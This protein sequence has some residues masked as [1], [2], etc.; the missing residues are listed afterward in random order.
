MVSSVQ[1]KVSYLLLPEFVEMGTK[2]YST[3]SAPCHSYPTT[4]TMPGSSILRGPPFWK[5]FQDGKHPSGSVSVSNLVSHY[6]IKILL[7]SFPIPIF[8]VLKYV[9]CQRDCN[10]Y[11]IINSSPHDLLIKSIHNRVCKKQKNRCIRISISVF[12]A[13]K[14]MHYN[15]INPLGW[16]KNK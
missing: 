8:P 1:E 10:H 3:S 9:V 15:P 2:R 5:M 16:V 6:G 13:F 11:G 14:V 12:E 7:Y 4:P